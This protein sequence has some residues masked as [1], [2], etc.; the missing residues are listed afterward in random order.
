M[1][2]FFFGHVPSLNSQQSCLYK[3]ETS[4]NGRRESVAVCC[5][6]LQY[7]EAC[8]SMLQGDQ[9]GRQHQTVW[10][11]GGGFWQCVVVYS[12]V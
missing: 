9:E 7:V 4:T 11:R 5:S 2:A 8:Y 10:E 3:T 6:V 1:N 12:N